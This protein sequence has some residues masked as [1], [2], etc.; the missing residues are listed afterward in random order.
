[1]RILA[2]SG[3]HG[4]PFVDDAFLKRMEDLEDPPDVYISA[5]D[6]GPVSTT[7]IFRTL[8]NRD[9]PILY[10]QGNHVLHYPRE[11]NEQSS[12]EINSLPNVQALNYAK[13]ELDGWTFIGQDAGTDFTDDQNDPLRYHDL[14]EKS[15]DAEPGSTVL[16]THHAPL[17]IF[18]T[19]HSYPLHSYV[20]SSGTMHAGSLAIRHF[21]NQFGPRIH[22]FAHC[23]SD[24]T[25]SSIIDRTLFVNVC[26]LERRTRDG[27]YGITGSFEIIDTDRLITTTFHLSKNSPT[28]CPSCGEV[29][30]IVYRRCVNCTKGSAGIIP[31]DNLP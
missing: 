18:D 30:Y 12:E 13:F 11:V 25:R 28:V 27:R 4:N 23:H 17:G 1:L 16:V 26:H 24:G 2:F 20:D 19:G 15:K 3:S 7:H 31:S 21:V 29:N 9:I 6:L 22:I 10:V 8:A 5:G 14:V